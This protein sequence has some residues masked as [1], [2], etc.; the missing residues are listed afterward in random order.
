MENVMKTREELIQIWVA[1]RISKISN[2]SS[3]PGKDR[4]LSEYRMTQV[5]AGKEFLDIKPM[6]VTK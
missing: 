2:E 1:E 4:V 5:I 3:F 6:E